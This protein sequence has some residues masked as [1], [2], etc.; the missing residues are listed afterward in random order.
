MEEEVLEIKEEDDLY[1]VE[2]VYNYAKI[3]TVVEKKDLNEV[4]E[5]LN[6]EKKIMLKKI[7]FVKMVKL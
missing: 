6:L 1:H 5:K 4:I 2:F 3:E 7:I